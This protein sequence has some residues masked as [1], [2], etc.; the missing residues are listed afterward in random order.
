MDEIKFHK[1]K[2]I[3]DMEKIDHRIKELE[4]LGYKGKLYDK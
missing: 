3:L 4:K 2:I 1:Q